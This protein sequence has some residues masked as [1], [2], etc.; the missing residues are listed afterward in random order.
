MKL[1][2][3]LM[4]LHLDFGDFSDPQETGNVHYGHQD[5]TDD[6]GRS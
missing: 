3:L 4:I 5:H 1:N 6:T 2:E